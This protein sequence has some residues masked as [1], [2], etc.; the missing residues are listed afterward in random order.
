MSPYLA[1]LARLERAVSAV[2]APPTPAPNPSAVEWMAAPAV[3]PADVRASL[4]EG[5]ISE[6][7]AMGLAELFARRAA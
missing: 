3:L 4:D 5:L 7:D 1:A 6:D 2:V